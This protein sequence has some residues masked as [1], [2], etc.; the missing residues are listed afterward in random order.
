MEQS[1]APRPSRGQKIA[2]LALI[3]GPF[4]GLVIV[5]ISYAIMTFVLTQKY[6][7]GEI[8]FS[9]R[10]NVMSV[11]NVL[12]G[13]LGVIAVIGVLIGLPLGIYFLASAKKG[14]TDKLSIDDAIRF[15]WNG[16][17]THFFFLVL[18]LF[19]SF[20]VRILTGIA[21]KTFVHYGQSQNATEA[22]FVLRIVLLL[23][24]MVITLGWMNIGLKIVDGKPTKITDLFPIDQRIF[25]YII[26]SIVYFVI[27]I[28]GYL[29]LIVPGIILGIKYSL[30]GY[31][32]LEGAGPI[33][34]LKLSGQATQG[35]KADL[36]ALNL[37]LFLINLAGMLALLIGLLATIPATIIAQAYAYRKLQ[38]QLGT[39]AQT[40]PMAKA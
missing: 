11:V 17:K 2:G 31:F 20:L 8:P 39:T 16:M 1:P 36:F 6:E 18:V 9:T 19:T 5:F 23:V 37:L 25:N 14:G 26:G 13:F 3:I 33:E 38:A 40:Q 24:T 10:S 30:Y 22:G 7:T 35:A 21:E 27:V 32:I 28:V 4:V 12:L 34:A 15:G 29:L